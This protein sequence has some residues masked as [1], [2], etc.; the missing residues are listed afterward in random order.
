MK[1]FYQTKNWI[2]KRK[3]ILRRDGYM[4]MCCKRYGKTTQAT[5]VHHIYP[6]ELYPELKLNS[7]NLISLCEKC[8]NEMHNR[9]NHELTEKGNLLKKHIPPLKTLLKQSP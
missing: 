9:K 4:C 8:H 6:Y 2:E 7:F 3:R 5:T 1:N